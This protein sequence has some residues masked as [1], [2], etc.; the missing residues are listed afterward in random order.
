[1]L[2][3]VKKK[4]NKFIANQNL[5]RESFKREGIAMHL[6]G[7]AAMTGSGGE[8]T[9]EN[10]KKCEDFL[11]TKAGVFS[12]I[13]GILKMPMI[14]NMALSGKA[15]DVLQCPRSIALHILPE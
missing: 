12:S 2:I 9:L 10:L 3:H 11:D 4:K 1:M 7:A 8:L 14:V 15:E 13:R 6:T 5:L